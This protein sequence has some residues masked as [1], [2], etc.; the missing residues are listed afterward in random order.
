MTTTI[1]WAWYVDDEVLRREQER[2]FAREWQYV[3][4]SG[5]AARP[6]DFFAC[7]LGSIP[8]VVVRGEDGEV[9]AFLNVCRHRGSTII[10]GPGHRRTLQCP[11]HAWTYGLDGLLRSAPR[12][13]REPAFDSAELSLV[14]LAVGSWGPFVFVNPDAGAPP[15]PEVLADLPERV[16]SAGVDV[17]SL[18]FHHRVEYTVPANRKLVCENFLECYHCPVAH[19]GFSALVDTSVE[20][21]RVETAAGFSSQYTPLRPDGRGYDASG[22]VQRGQFHLIWPNSG[23]NI[24]PGRP[25]LS[26]GPMQP[27]GTPATHRFLDYF[28]APGADEA[29]IGELLEFDDQVGREDVELV[30]R[31]QDG[32]STGLVGHG[33]LLTSSEALVI[34]FQARVAQALA[35]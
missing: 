35:D 30:R 33:R 4:H 19:P 21:Y 17:E 15:L 9:R 26:I 32:V 25:N 28:F 23:I 18:E 1:P 8:A 11:Y 10:E 27:A 31:V 13:D 22:D 29:W 20:A 12:A 16:A 14:P 3:G 7:R 6:G 34:D 24:F 2:I 5:Q